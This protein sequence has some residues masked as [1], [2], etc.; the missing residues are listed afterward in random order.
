VYDAVEK[1]SPFKWGWPDWKGITA[2]GINHNRVLMTLDALAQSS[3]MENGVLVADK[4]EFAKFTVCKPMA[5]AKQMLA[6]LEKSG[7]QT[8]GLDD[9]NAPVFTVE[10]PANPAMLTVLYAYFQKNRGAHRI[11]SHRFAEDPAAQPRETYFLAKTDGEPEERRTVYYWL[12]DEAVKHGYT[13]AERD[14]MGCYL[15][16]KGTRIF[17]LLGGGHSYHE[18]DF[19]HTPPYKMAAKVQ[20]LKV[21]DTHPG[22]IDALMKRFPDSFGRPWTQC[23]TC[24]KNFRECTNRINFP[25]VRKY[26]YHCG[27]HHHLYFHDPAFEDVQAIYELFILEKEGN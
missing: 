7:L 21:F 17:M 20:Y 14:H 25:R 5:K 8:K 3:R 1:G 27:H 24:K 10:Y 9:K 11:L 23:Y 12:Y 18:D 2:E 16:T 19:L 13:P 6:G 22:K 4:G 15:Y 26:Y